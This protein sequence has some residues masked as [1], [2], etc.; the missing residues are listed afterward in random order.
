MLVKLR[1]NGLLMSGRF[2]VAKCNPLPVTG[3]VLLQI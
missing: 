1:I 3:I 2:V